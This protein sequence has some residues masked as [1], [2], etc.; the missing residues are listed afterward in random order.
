[1]RKL[2]ALLALCAMTALPLSVWADDG[3]SYFAPA[4]AEPCGVY[5]WDVSDDA[6]K[7][8][9]DDWSTATDGCHTARWNGT[10][11]TG[12]GLGTAK[13]KVNKNAQA[14]DLSSPAGG[15][16]CRYAKIHEANMV[17]AWHFKVADG[18][19]ITVDY[20]CR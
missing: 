2:A 10:V 1:M 7:T 19:E 9:V 14:W 18:T 5:V 6:G 16:Y 20:D 3:G 17:M 4:Q 11:G 15:K 8:P 12:P 13:F